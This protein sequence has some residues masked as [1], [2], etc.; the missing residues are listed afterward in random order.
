MGKSVG[1]LDV[2]QLSFWLYSQDLKKVRVRVVDSTGQIFQHN[3][4]VSSGGWQQ[5]KLTRMKSSTS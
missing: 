4:S 3:I 5:V 1:A 2:Q